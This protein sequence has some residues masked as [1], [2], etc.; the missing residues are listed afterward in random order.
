MYS[1]KFKERITTAIL[2][3]VGLVI[4]LF[5]IG[6]SASQA[7]EQRHQNQIECIQSGGH[8]DTMTST[9]TK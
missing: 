8:T 4:L 1:S 6:F 2:A 5:L 9:C 3:F 7:V